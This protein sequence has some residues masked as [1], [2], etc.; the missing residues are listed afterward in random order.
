MR[1]KHQR[2]NLAINGAARYFNMYFN[3]EFRGPDWKKENMPDMIAQHIHIQACLNDIPKKHHEQMIVDGLDFYK[4]HLEALLPG[5]V[6][7][8]IANL[9]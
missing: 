1:N 6:P 8:E 9:L 2:A 7:V 5:E 4:Q 3:L